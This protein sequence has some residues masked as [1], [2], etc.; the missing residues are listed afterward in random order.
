[1][2]N[3]TATRPLQHVK[4]G[5]FCESFAQEAADRRKAYT[6]TCSGHESHEPQDKLLPFSRRQGRDVEEIL[7]D[8]KSDDVEERKWIANS[9][10][11]SCY[12]KPHEKDEQML[13]LGTEAQDQSQNITGKDLRWM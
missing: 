7:S 4:T 2:N 10:R 5:D 6:R 1:M 11:L 12:R 3:S 8:R 9:F 13:M